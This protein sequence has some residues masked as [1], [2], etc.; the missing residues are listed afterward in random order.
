MIVLLAAIGIMSAMPQEAELI[1]SEIKDQRVTHVGCREF[2]EGIFE[3]KEVV[4]AL[5]GVGKV[6]AAT[7]AAL[8]IAQFGVEEIVFTGVAGGGKG[9][10][11]GD[12]V[13]GHTYLQHDMDARPVF[14]QFFILS[15]GKQKLF[16]NADRVDEMRRAAIRYFESGISFPSLGIVS[17]K[18][19]EGVIVSGDQFVISSHH[20]KA[21]VDRVQD[22][23]PNGFQAIEM[24]GAAVAQ[25][26]HELKIPFIVVRAISDQADHSAPVD[27]QVFMEQVASHYS[28]G[29]LKEYLKKSFPCEK[30]ATKRD[31]KT[32]TEKMQRQ[33]FP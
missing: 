29:I 20:H 30:T 32:T 10:Q 8:M 21:I 25:V 7:T 4:F 1:R 14:P 15:L 9:V 13:I 22:V 6:S 23:L 24:E 17:P 19:H 11:I 31:R 26:C 5:S 12:I 28:F 16:A 18:V 27:F 33:E 3:G 2:V